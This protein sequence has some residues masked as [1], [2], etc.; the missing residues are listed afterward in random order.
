MFSIVLLS[1]LSLLS[2]VHAFDGT[3][4]GN[5]K[6]L[7]FQKGLFTV[8]QRG[9]TIHQLRCVG[10]NACN[11]YEPDV[12]QCTNVGSDGRDYQW[13]CEASLPEEY[14][15]GTTTVSCEG[16]ESSDDSNILVGSCG[17]EYTLNGGKDVE[18]KDEDN[19]TMVM[20]IVI[21]VIIFVLI[22]TSQPSYE[23]PIMYYNSGYRYSPCMYGCYYSCGHSSG[24][25]RR[26]GGGSGGGSSS[27]TAY[28]YGSTKRR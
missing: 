26:S 7:T 18:N 21:V 14:S 2:C 19:S 10:G 27:R 11:K 1:L 22:V 15:F 20:V 28:G 5:V 25:R 13:K 23:N 17:L 3:D 9:A 4:L 6:S 24:R 12:V 16:F 8:A